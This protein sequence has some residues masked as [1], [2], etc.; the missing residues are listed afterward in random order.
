MLTIDALRAYGA[1]VEDGLK[2]CLDNEAF[3]LRL[4]NTVIPDTKVGELSA[5]IAAGD[6][7]KAFELAHALKGMY[8]NLSLTPLSGPVSE[9]T[10]LLRSRTVTDYGPLMET[11]LSRKAELEELAK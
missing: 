5:A 10:E 2:R 11:I 7:D 3:Y 8:G 1:D 6:L 9:I 4:V